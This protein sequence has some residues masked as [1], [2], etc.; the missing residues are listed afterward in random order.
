MSCVFPLERIYSILLKPLRGKIYCLYL[1][2]N[3]WAVYLF[4][5]VF[6]RRKG[7]FGGLFQYFFLPLLSSLPDSKQGHWTKL[8]SRARAKQYHKDIIGKLEKSYCWQETAVHSNEG[9]FI[10]VCPGCREFRKVAGLPPV[11]AAADSYYHPQ[12]WGVKGESRA[13]DSRCS[14]RGQALCLGK[15]ASPLWPSRRC[16]GQSLTHSFL[17]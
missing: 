2:L 12:S 11:V 15:A 4:N 13:E 5:L 1:Q 3:L 9:R 14:T 17:S 10:K 16:S 6:Y 7:L 8:R